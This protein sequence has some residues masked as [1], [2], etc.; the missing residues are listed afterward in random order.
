MKKTES[1]VEKSIDVQKLIQLRKK[2]DVLTKVL[3]SERQIA[4][5]KN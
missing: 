3:L 2:V 5:L 1:E 4:M